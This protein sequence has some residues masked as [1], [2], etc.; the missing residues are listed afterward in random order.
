MLAR[1]ILRADWKLDPEN[2]SFYLQTA[3]AMAED[4]RLTRRGTEYVDPFLYWLNQTPNK[5]II[6]VG[7]QLSF[8]LG[9]VE[10][11]LHG[12]K[13]SNGARG[14]T[15]NLRRIGVKVIKA[16]DHTGA[17]D[18]GA[19]GAGTSSIL[20]PEYIGPV[21]SWT[22]NHVLLQWDGKRQLVFIIKGRYRS[23]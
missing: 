4:C 7:G 22:Q 5:N 18:E 1:W 17:I 2:A 16:H 10:L 12:D 19:Y 13:G 6:P 8:I 21:S 3:C 9:G 20:D 15:R 23:E 11:A 14:S